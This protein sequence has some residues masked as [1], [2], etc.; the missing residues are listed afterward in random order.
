MELF[1]ISL[2]PKAFYLDVI[3]ALQTGIWS[4]TPHFLP[5]YFGLFK[6][7]PLCWLR[8]K[9]LSVGDLWHLSFLYFTSLMNIH[10]LFSLQEHLLPLSYISTD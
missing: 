5:V 8:P 7:I 1:G 6:L 10:E 9:I 3:H 4:S 2:D